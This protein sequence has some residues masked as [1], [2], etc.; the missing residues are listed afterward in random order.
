MRVENRKARF[1]YEIKDRIE[2]GVQLTGPEVKAAKLG[3]VEF[4]SA[5]AK[6]GPSKFR[7]QHEVWL[8]GMQIFPYKHADNANYDSMRTRK[9]LLHQ[10][11]ILGL[12]TKMKSGG[13]TL[14][15]TAIYTKSGLVKIELGLARG[16]RKYEKREVIKERES[17]RAGEWK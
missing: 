5:H 10:K 6:I 11:E 14:I 8:A 17:R 9:L 1:D 16:K 3:Q 13:L 7:G 12:Q 2:A 15:P 4:G